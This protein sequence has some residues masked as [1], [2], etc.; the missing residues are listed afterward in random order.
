MQKLSENPCFKKKQNKI[1]YTWV[2]NTKIFKNYTDH[3]SWPR[4]WWSTK[5]KTLRSVWSQNSEQKINSDK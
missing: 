2:R 3:Q 1:Q 5:W 4:L